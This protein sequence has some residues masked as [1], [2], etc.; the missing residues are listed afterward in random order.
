MDLAF[1]EEQ[2]AL[3]RLARDIFDGHVTSD[4]LKEIEAGPER[5]DRALWAELARS[6]LLGTGIPE[7]H[8]GIGGGVIEVCL[9]L[10]QAGATVAP[11]PLWPAL[12]LGALP[13]ARYGSAEQRAALLP[14]V[15]C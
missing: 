3:G 14:R 15:G 4:R 10:E 6:N 11:V 7:T 8:G 9:V 12:A 1:S 2:E 5:F 13:L